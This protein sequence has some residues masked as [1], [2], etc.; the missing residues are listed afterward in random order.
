MYKYLLENMRV[1]Y[2]I[3][4]LKQKFEHCVSFDMQFPCY[5]PEI[6]QF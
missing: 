3:E 5:F 1:P 2:E 4:K 6:M